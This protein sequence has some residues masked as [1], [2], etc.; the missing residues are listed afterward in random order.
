MLKETLRNIFLCSLF[1]IFILTG[2][3]T[4]KNK[5]AKTLYIKTSLLLE[6]FSKV[7]ELRK[8]R[9]AIGSQIETNINTLKTT[10]LETETTFSVVESGTIGRYNLLEYENAYSNLKFEEELIKNPF[11]LF[12]QKIDKIKH[13]KPKVY[14]RGLAKLLRLYAENQDIKN[15]ERVALLVN[16]IPG[17]DSFVIIQRLSHFTDAASLAQLGEFTNYNSYEAKLALA[18][19]E[20]HL[21]NKLSMPLKLDEL[22][23]NDF[24]DKYNH[25]KYL[26][27]QTKYNPEYKARLCS[28]SVDK[29]LEEQEDALS[30]NDKFYHYDDA[31]DCYLTHIGIDERFTKAYLLII[32]LIKDELAVYGETKY[33][34]HYNLKNINTL[35]FNHPSIL[36]LFDLIDL[37]IKA[38]NKLKFYGLDKPNDFNKLFM[39]DLVSKIYLGAAVK[40]KHTRYD[41]YYTADILL[42]NKTLKEEINSSVI[43][44]VKSALYATGNFRA[45]RRFQRKFKKA[46]D[47]EYLAKEGQ[48]HSAIAELLKVAE[49][50]KLNGVE[51]VG[52]NESN[53]IY[54]WLNTTQIYLNKSD[55]VDSLYISNS[56]ELLDNLFASFDVKA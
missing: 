39:D 46:I 14:T 27:L 29:I 32:K 19:A 11:L 16:K 21:R 35:A 37:N 56:K 52:M 55:E 41:N 22:F 9:L 54:D 47:V 18:I 34:V 44:N 36:E 1:S 28:T 43:Y 25:K 13:L 23:L 42:L 50:I 8:D 33:R 10:Y 17:A 5:E 51:S 40:G 4:D 6:Q 7:K 30:K 53:V 38:H 3:I 24:Y 45:A 20:G 2:C 49:R 15:F 31:F 26:E 48:P 12:E